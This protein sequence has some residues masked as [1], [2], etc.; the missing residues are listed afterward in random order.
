[1]HCYSC[2]KV[3]WRYG[4]AHNIILVTFITG[5]RKLYW[6][7]CIK[8]ARVICQL[9][10]FH[11]AANNFP[12]KPFFKKCFKIVFFVLWR[13]DPV[14]ELQFLAR[15]SS[16]FRNSMSVDR[17]VVAVSRFLGATVACVMLLFVATGHR[18]S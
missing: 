6:N 12:S 7:G 2:F 11:F 10:F 3:A 8:S 5:H 15:S 1:M 9:I 4:G 14:L 18:K 13:R 17:I 16:V